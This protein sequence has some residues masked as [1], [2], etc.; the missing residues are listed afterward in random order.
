MNISRVSKLDDFETV[1]SEPYF[2]QHLFASIL[3]TL[4]YSSNDLTMRQ[5]EGKWSSY[6]KY[7]SNYLPLV[8]PLEFVMNDLTQYLR[9][10]CDRISPEANMGSAEGYT[11]FQIEN[12]L[13]FCILWE[14][15]DQHGRW[16]I[17]RFI[18]DDGTPVLAKLT[19]DR[20]MKDHFLHNT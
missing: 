13:I 10:L 9:D 20:Y 16:I 3:Y 2:V 11:C 7:K 19:L 12:K 17:L 8:S 6:V 14:G 15:T 1:K 5:H 18:Y 4:W